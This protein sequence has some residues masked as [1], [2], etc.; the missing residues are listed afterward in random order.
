VAGNGAVARAA[1]ARMLQGRGRGHEGGGEGAL[2]KKISGTSGERGVGAVG[3]TVAVDGGGAGTVVTDDGALALRRLTKRVN[4]GDAAAGIRA[5]ETALRGQDR[6]TTMRFVVGCSEWGQ[7]REKDAE[8]RQRRPAPFWEGAGE[9]GGQG[10]GSTCGG[11]G[12]RARGVPADQRA[13]PGQQRPE[14]GGRHA[15]TAG[16]T[17]GEGRG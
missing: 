10:T 7:R 9:A 16:R 17:E 12:A 8:A 6:R 13:A 15:R 14:V 1:T 4:G 3:G 2:S 5:R 11:I